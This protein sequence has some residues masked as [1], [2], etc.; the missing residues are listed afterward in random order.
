MLP[1]GN[2]LCVVAVIDLQLGAMVEA[3]IFNLTKHH[4][5]IQWEL[6]MTGVMAGILRT[7]HYENQ[8]FLYNSNL[9]EQ[10][11]SAHAIGSI[12]KEH[13]LELS[14]PMCLAKN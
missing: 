2:F 6:Q 12:L 3:F 5:I 1:N 10:G 9:P 7:E 11:R 14:C 13:T 8:V 4:V